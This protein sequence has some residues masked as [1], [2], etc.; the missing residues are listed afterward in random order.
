MKTSV[1]LDS[2]E[3]VL[4]KQGSPVFETE[5]ATGESQILSAANLWTRALE[6]KR[7]ILRGGFSRGNLVYCPNRK[8]DFL[9]LLVA[10]AMAGGKFCPIK[11]GESTDLYDQALLTN[12]DRPTELVLKT[13]G[14]LG[15]PKI[16]SL[17]GD[18]ILHQ[19]RSFATSVGVEPDS[20]R[21]IFLPLH[22]CFG[23]I[24]D[25]LVGLF[26]KQTIFLRTP[27]QFS[28][29]TVFKT[30]QQQNIRDIS[31]VPRMVEILL[32]C[33]EKNPEKMCLLRN[34]RVH[35]GG[36]PISASLRQRSQA[37]FDQVIE[38]YGLT[39][40]AGGVLLNGRA[41]QCEVELNPIS[42]KADLYELCVKSPALGHFAAAESEFNENGC[43]RTGDVAARKPDG[44]IEVIGR[45]GDFFKDQSGSW[46]SLAALRERLEL[47]FGKSILALTRSENR[48]GILL[49]TN[50][51]IDK[52][53]VSSYL[54]RHFGL[55]ADFIYIDTE[56]VENVL[57][58]SQKKSSAD[59][60][61]EWMERK[62]CA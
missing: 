4:R 14:S 30:L 55:D 40:C 58:R 17:S 11:E 57:E 8:E 10:S 48:C 29:S 50:S 22:H 19:I 28:P 53:S 52:I 59:A 18:A 51:G 23:L 62:K 9:V 31:L 24:M 33:A 43:Y 20:G 7:E 49:A 61:S 36:S 6:K 54:D 2:L 1:W 32:D 3:E 35:I 41:N 60:F 25:L 27:N 56:R 15:H 34:L 46:T 5:T 26:S 12:I 37:A 42:E 38:G 47:N 39:E 44:S 21:L 13:S 16:V 45:K